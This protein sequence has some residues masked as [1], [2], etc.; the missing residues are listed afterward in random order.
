M[1]NEAVTVEQVDEV[2]KPTLAQK[3]KVLGEEETGI[4][5]VTSSG[6]ILFALDLTRKVVIV[7]VQEDQKY[8]GTVLNQKEI[9]EACEIL[10]ACTQVLAGDG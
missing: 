9:G 5:M 6:H 10:Q 3:L 4:S 2:K 8:A 1:A 7:E